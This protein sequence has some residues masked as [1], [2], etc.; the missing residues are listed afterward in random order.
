MT[1]NELGDAIEYSVESCEEDGEVKGGGDR[2]ASA[3]AKP[4]V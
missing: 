4:Q 2:G 3:E 1:W